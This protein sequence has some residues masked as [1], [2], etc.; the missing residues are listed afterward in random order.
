MK[1]YCFFII[2]FLFLFELNA[3]YPR[4]NLKFY[5]IDEEITKLFNN[6][7]EVDSN[8]IFNEFGELI[9]PYFIPDNIDILENLDS[10]YLNNPKYIALRKWD[11]IVI[12][13]IKEIQIIK[14]I[15][16]KNIKLNFKLTQEDG[17]SLYELTSQN[18]GKYI[19]LVIDNKVKII[20][21]LPEPIFDDV[22]IQGLEINEAN[23]LEQILRN[24]LDECK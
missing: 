17:R 13:Q 18:I 4:L 22:S 7:C 5:V 11:S 3:Q 21:F 14:K 19:A 15:F 12:H 8:L 2:F 16:D 23:N 9:Y 1:K 6:Y 24:L 10:Y 20:C